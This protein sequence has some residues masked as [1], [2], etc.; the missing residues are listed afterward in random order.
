MKIKIKKI[1]LRLRQWLI[2]NNYQKLKHL[3]NS[4]NLNLKIISKYIN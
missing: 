2:K 3:L 1:N 4:A